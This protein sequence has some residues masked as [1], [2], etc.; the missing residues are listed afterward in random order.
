MT[1]MNSGC[2]LCKCSSVSLNVLGESGRDAASAPSITDYVRNA[3]QGVT[4]EIGLLLGLSYRGQQFIL[5]V[6][7][8]TATDDCKR[9]DEVHWRY[10]VGSESTVTFNE[11][12]LRSSCEIKTV[13]DISSTA[14]GPRYEAQRDQCFHLARLGLAAS[15]SIDVDRSD[16]VRAAQSF[17]PP[18]GLLLFGPPG[19][20]K[21]T[22]LRRT[23]EH[24]G[25]ASLEISHSILLS[26][27]QGEAEQELRSVFQEAARRAPCCI[28]IDNID[29]LCCQRSKSGV[30]ELQKRIV[31]CMLSLIDGLDSGGQFEKRVFVL[32][33]TTRPNDVDSALRRSGR[34]D[35]EIEIGVPSAPEREQILRLLLEMSSVHIADSAGSDEGLVPTS[36]ATRKFRVSDALVSDIARLAHGMVGADLLLVVKEAFFLA[37]RRQVTVNS[38]PAPSST[39]ETFPL[40]AGGADSLSINLAD[41]FDSLSLN[42]EDE[43]PSS[44]D[45]SSN[46]TTP[47]NNLS[48]PIV[49]A[50]HP[51]VVDER[52]FLSEA[53]FREA[54]SRVSP[55]ALRE[56]VVE[57]PSVR[58]TDIG[59]MESVKQALKEVVEWP[60][61][62]PELFQSLGVAP[63]KGVLLYGPPG[64]SKTLM[65]K[66]LATESSMNFL[67]V[68]GPELL[69][70]WLG[71]SEKAIQTLFR[72][73][74]AAAPSII[75]F[76]EIDALAGKRGDTSSGVGDRVLSQLLTE[77]DGI[78][79]LKQV[80]VLAAT[81]RPDMLD[82]ALIRPGRIDRK[83]YVPPPDSL[84]R[85][86][87]LRIE[88][89]KMPVRDNPDGSP[90]DL[91]R[92]VRLSEGFSGAE[93]VAVTSEAAMLAIEE[94]CTQLGED[95]LLTAIAGIKPQITASMLQFYETF[96][97]KL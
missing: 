12:T 41:E 37:L 57:V 25:C 91:P 32:G 46:L 51:L 9:S 89:R 21:T 19:T 93:I 45:I 95:H 84:S 39:S 34:L 68:K 52:V 15:H 20:G 81:N 4:L 26:G 61:Q 40:S 65:A 36:A 59:G 70:K 33:A 23:V 6:A 27:V 16:S 63:P 1:E 43:T 28:L 80:I 60:L 94:D 64:C 38:S 3:L 31:S 66:A 56:V 67:A 69:S 72:R 74:R 10:T 35:R 77:L 83:I 2:I 55:S 79:G 78:H 62:H 85:E 29:L 48:V 30:S 42:Q 96:S 47:P 76:D 24:M 92:L 5:E 97:A 44:Q 50:T 7:T 88:L 17:R 75:F 13:A 54:L 73:A 18:K 14:E 90:L 86:Q 11:P 71:E 53:D 49:T 58:W 87:I 82:A 8:L 22:L